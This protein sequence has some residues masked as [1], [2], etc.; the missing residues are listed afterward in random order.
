[1]EFIPQPQFLRRFLSPPPK[2]KLD[3]EEGGMGILR[4]SLSLELNRQFNQEEA[5]AHQENVVAV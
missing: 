5:K 2:K 3:A 4:S 1:M